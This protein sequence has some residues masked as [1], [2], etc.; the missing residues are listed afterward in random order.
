MYLYWIDTFIRQV[1]VS[2]LST[3]PW[4]WAMVHR[5]LPSPLNPAGAAFRLFSPV[6]IYPNMYR[7]GYGLLSRWSQVRNLH[8]PIY[9]IKKA[10]PLKNKDLIRVLSKPYSFINVFPVIDIFLDS[11]LDNYKNGF[12]TNYLYWSAITQI[13]I[14]HLI[15]YFTEITTLPFLCP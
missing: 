10:P 15:S 2:P 12:I 14:S 6:R 7:T 11:I 8:G 3:L 9:Y 13:L 1:A 5:Y 4:D